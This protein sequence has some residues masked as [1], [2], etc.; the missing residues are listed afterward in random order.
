MPRDTELSKRA[1]GRIGSESINNA[2]TIAGIDSFDHNQPMR[3]GIGVKNNRDRLS[4]NCSSQLMVGLATRFASLFAHLRVALVR[5]ADATRVVR[6]A[7]ARAAV[8][9]LRW[10]DMVMDVVQWNGMV[11]R[12]T[13]R[14][15]GRREGKGRNG[16]SKGKGKGKGE[17]DSDRAK[18]NQGKGLC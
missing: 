2:N 15:K 17:A 13:H 10:R 12:S 4:S 1:K 8:C 16:S 11:T 18:L 3:M 5:A 7:T 9:T 6:L 14:M